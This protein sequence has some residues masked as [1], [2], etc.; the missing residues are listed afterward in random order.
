[1]KHWLI[2]VAIVGLLATLR[3]QKA[4]ALPDAGMQWEAEFRDAERL[5]GLPDDLLA[6]MAQQESS[7]QPDAVSTAGAVGLMQIVPRWHPGV[8]PL[9]PLA[10]IYYAGRYMRENYDRFGTWSEALAAYNWGPTALAEHGLANA[11]EET[12]N[13]VTAITGDLGII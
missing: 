10:S 6:R 3:P 7:Y 11:P 1:M 13:Y 2:I 5:F 12:R 8:D 9:D 4:W